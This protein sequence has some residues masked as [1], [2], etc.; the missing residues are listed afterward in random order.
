M[1]AEK[2]KPKPSKAATAAKLGDETFMSATELRHYMTE[3]EMAKA[4]KDVGSTDRAEQARAE[5]MKSLATPIELTPEKLKEITR[6]L[7]HKLRSAAERGQTELMVMRFPNTLCTDKGRALNNSERTWPDTLVGRPRQ[8]YEFW[9][10]HLQPAGY[11][12]KAL[13]VDWPGG[14]PGD[15]G[16]FL[17]WDSAKR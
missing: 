13:I 2:V 10:E 9:R 16:F 11:R 8:A 17:G 15:V 1:Q 7:L 14:L 6:S 4:S 3:V 5:L 12:L